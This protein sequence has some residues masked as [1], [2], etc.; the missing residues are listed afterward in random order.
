MACNA[1][2]I[3]AYLG[4]KRSSIHRLSADDGKS[5]EGRN[6]IEVNIC[7]ISVIFSS[8]SRSQNPS[9]AFNLITQLNAFY[10]FH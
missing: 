3:A 1:G 2:G 6:F 9:M 8:Y 4:G 10:G 7:S 5:I